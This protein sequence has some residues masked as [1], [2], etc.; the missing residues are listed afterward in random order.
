M[1]DSLQPHGSQYTGFSVHYKLLELAKTHVHWVSDAIQLS[2]PLL[3]S[4]P[5]AF[6]LSQNQSFPI[7]RFFTSGSQSTRASASA[8]VLPMN[9]WDW[10]PL[11]FTGLISLPSKGLSRVYF[12]TTVQKHQFFHAQ[13]SYG[14]TLTPWLCLMAK[15]LFFCLAWLFSFLSAF[16]HFSDYIYSLTKG[17]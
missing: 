10:F 5:P 16:S 12:N 9:I 3:S 11:G 7:S 17:F 15:I 1:S 13:P 8:S 4:S 14:P 2:H 6:Y